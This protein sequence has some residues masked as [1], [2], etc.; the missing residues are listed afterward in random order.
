MGLI[1]KTVF[2]N[3]RTLLIKARPVGVVSHEGR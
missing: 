3:E 1:G 2:D